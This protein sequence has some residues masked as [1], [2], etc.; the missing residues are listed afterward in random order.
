LAIVSRELGVAVVAIGLRQVEEVV[1]EGR[2][3][4]GSLLCA[5]TGAEGLG[6]VIDLFGGEEIEEGSGR[7]RGREN[8]GEQNLFA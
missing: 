4:L 6:S 5:Q 2:L 7:V 3:H 8:R 1:S